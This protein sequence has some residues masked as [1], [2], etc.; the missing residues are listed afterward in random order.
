[1][2]IQRFYCRQWLKKFDINRTANLIH[3]K[4][5]Y[6]PPAKP[7]IFS[8]PLLT[9]R[10]ISHC[11]RY[12]TSDV[13]QPYVASPEIQ[14]PHTEKKVLLDVEHLKK[15][16]EVLNCTYAEAE[17]LCL[18]YDF[19]HNIDLEY[20]KSK[21]AL[22]LSYGLPHSFIH[23]H[24]RAMWY[25]SRGNLTE[26]LET[27]QKLSLFDY[28]FAGFYLYCST[29]ELERGLKRVL[30]IKEALEGCS[31]LLA[32]V[33]HRLDISEEEAEHFINTSPFK[34]GYSPIRL[35][36]QF[37]FFLHE[38]QV[39]ADYLL[40]HYILLNYSVD[41]LRRR[42]MVMKKA[43]ITDPSLW[44]KYW[45]YTPEQFKSKFGTVIKTMEEDME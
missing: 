1:M 36:E 21:V 41:R 39:D 30:S 31:D 18:R 25:I 7:S 10:S 44:K 9:V 20:L 6:G 27:L 13:D 17:M 26:R 29:R 3:I 42:L 33:Q 45:R 24:L 15:I 40:T 19:L 35:K 32:Y 16:A 22:M 4:C 11:N 8:P 28:R 38:V 43:G 14:T 5:L 37:D 12:S 2:K 34:R 23:R